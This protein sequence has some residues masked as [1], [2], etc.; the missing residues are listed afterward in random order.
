[1]QKRLCVL[2]FSLLSLSKQYDVVIAHRAWELEMKYLGQ[3]HTVVQM[4]LFNGWGSGCW[5]PV[6]SELVDSGCI[7]STQK[8]H[9]GWGSL[10]YLRPGQAVWFGTIFLISQSCNVLIY[11]ELVVNYIKVFE[12]LNWYNTYESNLLNCEVQILVVVIFHNNFF[13]MRLFF[14]VNS[15]FSFL[16]SYFFNIRFFVEQD[17]PCNF[18]Y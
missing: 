18:V 6:G 11:E 2:S 4:F 10:V 7:L 1:M 3:S 16:F 13:F 9:L 15:H 12:N 14:P 17:C 8:H 5:N